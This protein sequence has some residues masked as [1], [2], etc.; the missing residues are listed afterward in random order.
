M[1]PTLFIVG[2]TG[3]GKTSTFVKLV[4]DGFNF[5]AIS[6]D[7]R[8]IYKQMDIS[9]GKDIPDTSIFELVQ[10][11]NYKKT[12]Y[13][14]GYYRVDTTKLWLLDATNP[15]SSF[16]SAIYSNL[17][18]LAIGQI[19][20]TNH[21]PIFVGGTGRYLNDFI[22]SPSTLSIPQNQPLRNKLSSLDLLQLQKYLKNINPKRLFCMN[23]SDK[24]NPRRLTR[25]IE[26]LSYAPLI[27]P[28]S[29]KSSI[30]TQMICLTAPLDLIKQ[31]IIERVKNR[32]NQGMIEEVESLHKSYPDFSSYQSFHTPGIQEITHYLDHQISL[33]Q[34]VELWTQREINYAKRQLTW[35]KYQTHST[36]FDISKPNWYAEI[37]KQLKGWNYVSNQL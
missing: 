4:N 2:P 23:N 1:N 19:T 34:A 18:H 32:L 35:F 29:S 26:V 21:I 15:D 33:D 11:I 37:V 12:T 31:K 24:N 3:V 5:E 16:S 17:A 10:K 30:D 28:T 6:A 7:S 36:W 13:S 14:L 20:K 27:E 9:T 8:Q 25:A 22:H